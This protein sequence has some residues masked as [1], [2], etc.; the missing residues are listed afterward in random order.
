MNLQIHKA[1]CT[2]YKVI[3]KA[4]KQHSENDVIIKSELD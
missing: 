4:F 2:R 1:A 3:E